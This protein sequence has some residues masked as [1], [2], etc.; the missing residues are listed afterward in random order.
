[1]SS[2]GGSNLKKRII[3]VVGGRNLTGVKIW[4]G[5]VMAMTIGG[6]MSVELVVGAS[7]RSSWRSLK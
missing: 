7:G 4:S 6:G 2:G 1:M 3:R 5:G